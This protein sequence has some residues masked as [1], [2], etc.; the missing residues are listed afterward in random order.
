MTIMTY[1]H[2]QGTN[3]SLK[4]APLPFKDPTTLD[5]H[6][7]DYRQL[8]HTPAEDSSHGGEDVAVYAHGQ[9]FHEIFFCLFPF[10]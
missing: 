4:E 1:F 10:S 6:N 3:S 2:C 5:I 9:C 7:K 8:S